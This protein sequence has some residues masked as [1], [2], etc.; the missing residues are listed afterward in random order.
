MFQLSFY[1][2]NGVIKANNVF[3]E[4]GNCFFINAKIHQQI[5]SEHFQACFFTSTEADNCKPSKLSATT[6]L[7]M[8][9]C[10]AT[11]SLLPAF[12]LLLLQG[13]AF[14]IV[15]FKMNEV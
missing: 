7:Q 6:A 3:E 13:Y 15:Y 9:L 12:P 8:F 1:Y 2:F 4:A 14:D 5:L 10:A 11:Y